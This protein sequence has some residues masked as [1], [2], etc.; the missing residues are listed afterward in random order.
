MAGQGERKLPMRH[1][2]SQSGG[3]DDGKEGG[4]RKQV[5]EQPEWMITPGLGVRTGEPLGS[6]R[7]VFS[8]VSLAGHDS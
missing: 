3:I 5:L 6:G 4:E 8:W 2:L 1:G 7:R